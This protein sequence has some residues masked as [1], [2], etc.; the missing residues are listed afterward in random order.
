MKCDKGMAD[1][2]STD[3]KSV[4][5]SSWARCPHFSHSLPTHTQQ[6]WSHDAWIQPFLELASVS[7]TKPNLFSA[8]HKVNQWSERLFSDLVKGTTHW[9]FS[10]SDVMFYSSNPHQLLQAEKL[11]IDIYSKG[12]EFAHLVSVQ[13]VLMRY[14]KTFPRFT[15]W[16]FCFLDKKFFDVILFHFKYK[17][18]RG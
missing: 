3:W 10:C 17:E 4:P 2:Q 1:K 12:M 14:R 6:P 7:K 13:G 8:T 9:K 16:W 15:N 5:T 11:S 18:Y